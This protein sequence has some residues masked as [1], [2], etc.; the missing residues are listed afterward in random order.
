MTI[1][2]SR[3]LQSMPL[4]ILGVESVSVLMATVM[5]RQRVTMIGLLRAYK[6]KGSPQSRIVL[7][8]SWLERIL[9]FH[10]FW[11]HCAALAQA[12][13]EVSVVSRHTRTSGCLFVV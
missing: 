5:L 13:L 10:P 1:A 7:S 8:Y 4:L 3:M 12:H 6:R 9:G 11:R 2:H